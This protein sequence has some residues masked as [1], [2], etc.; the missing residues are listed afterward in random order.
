L[1]CYYRDVIIDITP[2]MSVTAVVEIYL[3]AEESPS[4]SCFIPQKLSWCSLEVC[5]DVAT[6]VVDTADLIV[7]RVELKNVL[8]KEIEDLTPHSVHVGEQP[9]KV[10]LALLFIEMLEKEWLHTKVVKT[11]S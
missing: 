2:E 7:W 4:G 8:F 11:E 9:T 6:T 1:E 5:Q 10:G 3:T